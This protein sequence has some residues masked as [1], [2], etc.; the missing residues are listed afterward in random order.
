MKRISKSCPICNTEVYVDKEWI[1]DTDY[2]GIVPGYF[3]YNFTCPKCGLKLYQEDLE[4]LLGEI[5]QIKDQP[6]K[7][8]WKLLNYHLTEELGREP[9]TRDIFKFIENLKSP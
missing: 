2:L 8:A 1:D 6:L 7:N 4:K 5:D 3:R 9:D